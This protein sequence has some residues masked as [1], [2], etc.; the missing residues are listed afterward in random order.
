MKN[1]ENKLDLADKITKEEISE[2]VQVENPDRYDQMLINSEII[3]N[4]IFYINYRASYVNIIPKKA[5]FA[6]LPNIKK[7]FDN[8]C[9][10]GINALGELCKIDKSFIILINNSNC[11]L[12]TVEYFKSYKPNKFKVIEPYQLLKNDN[13]AKNEND[14]SITKN[15]S[16]QAKPIKNIKN[17]AENITSSIRNVEEKIETFGNKIETALDNISTS[18]NQDMLVI[19]QDIKNKYFALLTYD[20]KGTEIAE[21]Q[22]SYF[23]PEHTHSEDCSN[24]NGEKYVDCPKCDARHEYTCPSC[25]GSGELNCPTCRGG[26]V[27]CGRCSGKGNFSNGSGNYERCNSCYGRGYQTCSKC[28]GSSRV[29][30]SNSG[31][32]STLMGRAVDSGAGKEFCGGKG[33]I[34][35]K[36]CYGDERRYGKVDCKPCK[37]TGEI[38]TLLYLEIEVGSTNGEFYKYSN[39][40]IN[41]IKKKPDI[42]FPYFNRSE[43][44]SKSVYNDNNGL[45][46]E[47][48]DEYTDEYCSSIEEFAELKKLDEYPRVISEKISYDIIPH[49]TLEYNHILSGTIH[50]FSAVVSNDSYSIL[51]HSDPTATKKLDV[52]NVFKIFKWKI[53]KAFSTDKYK[54]KLDKR[55]ELYLLVRVAKADGQIEDS[56]KKV[57]IEIITHLNEFSNKEKSKLFELFSLKE[58]PE[59][60][61][62]ETIFSSLERAEIAIQNLNR[63]VVED[64]EE[65]AP[66]VMLV[67]QL[68]NMIYVNVG[69]Y[70]SKLS[71]FFKTWQVSVPI[72][73]FFLS[74]IGIIIYD[75]YNSGIES[76]IELSAENGITSTVDSNLIIPNVEDTIS[77]VNSNNLV[78]SNAATIDD[79]SQ[80]NADSTESISSDLPSQEFIS[81]GIAVVSV[82][83]AFFYNLPDIS[84]IRAAYLIKGQIVEF[85]TRSNDYVYCKYTNDSGVITEGWMRISDFGNFYK[86]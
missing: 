16:P 65:E 36:E 82:D 34:I 38:G 63:M 81:E 19:Y 83:K 39:Q 47:N 13:Y 66:E 3:R 27:R 15:T 8:Q 6:M 55:N 70:P 10:G 75:Y 42:I 53:Y 62:E 67:N 56:E 41:Q 17:I 23:I 68:K 48:H 18:S 7:Y 52:W 14:I 54:S 33:I 32:S 49:C 58:L 84:E 11:N 71:T 79:F 29:R 69:N 74:S 24:C 57:L 25:N 21:N 78:D 51:F 80:V 64:S 50:Q 86:K 45:I 26:E 12:Q 9:I 4:D 40:I 37:A 44:Q 31:N 77:S 46:T 72:L 20:Y 73:L 5:T 43:L 30:C 59:L 28:N 1:T 60:K 61:Q 76:P 22:S 2:R 85:T 35:C